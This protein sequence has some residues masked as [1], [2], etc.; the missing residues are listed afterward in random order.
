[1][2]GLFCAVDTP[3]IA[4]A[5][6]LAKSLGALPVDYKL[7]L[8][9]FTA[10]GPQGV[11]QFYDEMP[12][13]RRLFL[14]LKLHD[15]PNTVA[16]AVRSVLSL[17]VQ[18]LTLHA[19][20]GFEMLQA[21]EQANQATSAKLGREPLRLLAVTVL[22]HLQD[23]ALIDIGFSRTVQDQVLHLA[24]MAL[25]AGI[26]GL[27]C[28]GSD[29]AILR[30]KFG[31]QIHLVTP[32]IRLPQDAAADQKRIMTPSMALAAGAN[33]LVVGRPITAASDP[34]AASKGILQDMYLGS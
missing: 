3:D 14:D 2:A 9:F 34:A 4:R 24:D 27:V 13:Q 29:V 23:D 11:R 1:M 26:G 17:P 8:E 12:Q 32:G 31:R 22:T 6:D 7:G 15:I 5:L 28:A 20:G 30:K 33:D 25:R 10:L 21:A 16:A 19:G 18:Y